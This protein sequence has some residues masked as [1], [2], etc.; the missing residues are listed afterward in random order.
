[1]CVTNTC[2]A[3]KRAPY[4][5]LARRSLALR[6]EALVVRITLALV[7]ALPWFAVRRDR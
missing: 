7:G 4:D 2:Q 3:S 5:V 6:S 1:M